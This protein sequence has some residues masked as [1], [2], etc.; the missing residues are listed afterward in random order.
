M[1]GSSGPQGIPRQRRVRRKSG[2]YLRCFQVGPTRMEEFF[3]KISSLGIFLDQ[4]S[5]PLQLS[6]GDHEDYTPTADELVRYRLEAI[7]VLTRLV[8]SLQAFACQGWALLQGCIEARRYSCGEKLCD[9]HG[10][11]RETSPRL[12]TLEA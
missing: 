11:K 4:P 3:Q 2:K 10:V 12:Q 6:L 1:V 9:R 8:E 7:G 5:R